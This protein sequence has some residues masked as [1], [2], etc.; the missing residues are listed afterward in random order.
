M[1]KE[2]KARQ[3]REP[4]NCCHFVVSSR[5]FDVFMFCKK[6]IQDEEPTEEKRPDN[7]GSQ[8]I[9]ATLS[10]QRGK[11]MFSCTIKKK[12]KMRSLQRKK[13]KIT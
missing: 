3:H 7:I 11:L 10:Y 8:P 4:T 9:V 2:Q 1:R 13:G 5:K 6:E 12:Y